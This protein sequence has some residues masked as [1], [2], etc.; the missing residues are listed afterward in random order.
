MNNEQKEGLNKLIRNAFEKEIKI[1]FR[2]L[3]KERFGLERLSQRKEKPL[4]N[5]EKKEVKILKRLKKTG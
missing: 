4:M 5:T 3:G 2:K 1:E